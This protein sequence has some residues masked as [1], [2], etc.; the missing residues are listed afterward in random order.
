MAKTINC[1]ISAAPVRARNVSSIYKPAAEFFAILFMVAAV[2]AIFEN[3]EKNQNTAQG[4]AENTARV[5]ATAPS[6]APAPVSP[7]FSKKMKNIEPLG[8]SKI[9]EEGRLTIFVKLDGSART[10]F[11]HSEKLH[12]A[13]FKNTT[14]LLSFMKK[15]NYQSVA[16]RVN[17]ELSNGKTFDLAASIQQ[18][19]REK[20]LSE[21]F[22]FGQTDTDE[23]K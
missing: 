15:L 20:G 14:A 17:T 22:P 13:S 16:L 3:R 21:E 4:S 5:V 9:M 2:Y 11:Y 1:K 18:I 8:V 10:L 19:N 6:A 12:E 23:L 7:K